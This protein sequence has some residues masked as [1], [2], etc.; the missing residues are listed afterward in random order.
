MMTIALSLR[1]LV[2]QI[3]VNVEQM[4]NVLGRQMC[5]KQGRA[6]VVRMMNAPKHNIVV[7]VNAKV[8]HFKSPTLVTKVIVMFGYLV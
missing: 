3:S 2:R 6:D 8:C 5:V 4:H 7:L 1:I